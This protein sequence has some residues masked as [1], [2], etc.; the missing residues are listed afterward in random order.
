MNKH[1]GVASCSSSVCHGN[2]KSTSSYDVQL[3]EYIIWSHD[4]S[5]SKAYSVLMSDR[6]R[7]IAAKLGLPNAYDAKLCLDCHADN[8]PE[9]VRGKEFNLADGIGCEGVPRRC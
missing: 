8:V 1:L 5:H 3:N 6:S 4:D 7:A 9:S 2:V